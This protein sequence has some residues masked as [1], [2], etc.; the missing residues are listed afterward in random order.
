[1]KDIPLSQIECL[2]MRIDPELDLP[3]ISESLSKIGQLSPV[4]LRPHPER[5]G[6]FQVIFGNRRVMAAKKLGW[7]TISADV[8]DLS[9]IDAVL[10]A[11]SEN[12]ERKDF[13]DYE[14]ATLLEKLHQ[15]T[16][17]SYLE[18]ARMIG[19]SPA[20]VSQH[21]AMLHLFPKSI[22]SDEERKRVLYRLGEKQARALTKV[23]DTRE[24]WN[25]AKL[26]VEQDIAP[27]ELEKI[28]NRTRLRRQRDAGTLNPSASIQRII[29]SML[30]GFNSKDVRSFSEAICST[31]FSLFSSFPPFVEMDHDT[32][33]D[34]I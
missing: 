11:Y 32:A 4:R 23:Y 26:A 8:S 24:R 7:K 14:K 19:K 3:S 5:P 15:L 18:I 20:Y 21:V 17:K 33:L 29:Q 12:A 1:M 10:I 9:D 13:S 30:D 27:N 2:H 25:L 31:Q 16:G 28:C 6:M 22:D 34:H